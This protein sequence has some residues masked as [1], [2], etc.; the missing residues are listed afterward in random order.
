L[1]RGSYLKETL[2]LTTR[3]FILAV[4]GEK[5]WNLEMIQ[6]VLLVEDSFALLLTPLPVF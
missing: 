4:K 2:D 5:L 6:L 1:Y 3:K